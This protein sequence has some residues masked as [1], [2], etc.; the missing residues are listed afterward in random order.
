MSNSYRYIWPINPPTMN[1][2]KYF[3]GILN[4]CS[5]FVL[6]C[7]VILNEA[8]QNSM[9]YVKLLKAQKGI[10]VPKIQC[11]SGSEFCSHVLVTVINEFY[12]THLVIV[13]N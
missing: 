1:G 4:D 10:Q 5:H 12:S 2:V 6:I 13:H 8:E 3:Q 7:L 11:D 9:D